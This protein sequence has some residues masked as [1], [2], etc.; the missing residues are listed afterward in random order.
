[1]RGIS[2]TQDV[3]QKPCA[4]SDAAVPRLAARAGGVGLTNCCIGR[5]TPSSARS[6][7]QP[8]ASSAAERHR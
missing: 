4:A 8:P 5:L 3:S 1:M 7:G 2:P 6:R